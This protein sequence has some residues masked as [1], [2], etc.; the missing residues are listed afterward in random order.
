MSMLRRSAK[1]KNFPKRSHHKK[2]GNFCYKASRIAILIMSSNHLT[3][4]FYFVNYTF[5]Y[6]QVFILP[7]KC[8]F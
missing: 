8:I 5:L 1:F 6:F 2:F 7:G 4:I 3:V